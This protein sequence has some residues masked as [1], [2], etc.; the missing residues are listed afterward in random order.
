MHGTI[1]FCFGTKCQKFRINLQILS[2]V[3]RM[4]VPSK[5]TMAETLRAR[6]VC[7]GHMELSRLMGSSPFAM[8]AIGEF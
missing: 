8:R 2:L 6:R 5:R 1:A 4:G 7:I 3:K